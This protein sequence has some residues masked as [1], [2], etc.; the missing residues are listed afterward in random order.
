MVKRSEM[1][2]QAVYIIL[3]LLYAREELTATALQIM[4]H[5]HGCAQV[6]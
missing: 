5:M 3:G 1:P 2:Q 6:S 4:I